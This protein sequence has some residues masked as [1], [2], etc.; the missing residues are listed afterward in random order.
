[1]AITTNIIMWLNSKQSNEECPAIFFGVL[2]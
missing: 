1:M 2:T